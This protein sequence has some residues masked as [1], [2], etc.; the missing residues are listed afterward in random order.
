VSRALTRALRT[1]GALGCTGVVLAGCTVA[2]VHPGSLEVDWAFEAASAT[3]F[4]FGPP[5]PQPELR[6]PTPP[7]PA[8]GATT[9]PEGLSVG[10]WTLLASKRCQ[11]MVH[12][13]H[14]RMP[15]AEGGWVAMDQPTLT[16]DMA[17]C[18]PREWERFQAYHY[19]TSQLSSVATSFVLVAEVQL[20]RR[21]RQMSLL[22]VPA[23]FIATIPHSGKKSATA[24]KPPQRAHRTVVLPEWQG[25][26]IGS[27]LSDAAA[28]WH[29]R[30]GS[31]YY[32]QTV[33][34]RFGSYRDGSPL[35]RPTDTNHTTPELRWLPRRLTGASRQQ[36]IAV[37][38]QRPRM[39]YSHQYVGA[40]P[41]DS[42]ACAHLAA[43]IVFADAVA[44]THVQIQ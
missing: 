41:Q 25:I 21:G 5:A 15:V 14:T 12:T 44:D 35:W 3:C 37:K 27:R 43:R 24:T 20:S 36:A 23:A 32:G 4:W 39:V 17:P 34:P 19:K 2:H 26:G 10:D 22:R 6:V 30:Q 42:G 40:S 38:R 18:D 31:D 28:E 8:L 1:E 29:T 9:I 11:G 13:S 33:H 16:L 7:P